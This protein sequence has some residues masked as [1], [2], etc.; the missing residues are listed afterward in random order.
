M[1]YGLTT[2]GAWLHWTA[3]QPLARITLPD[4]T[5]LVNTN[6]RRLWVAGRRAGVT[7]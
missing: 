4:V 6:A 1:T 7:A 2:L 3:G 5:S